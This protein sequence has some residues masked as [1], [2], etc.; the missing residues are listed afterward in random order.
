MKKSYR[1]VLVDEVSVTD[2]DM[3]EPFHS[4]DE[5]EPNDVETAE[6][7]WSETVSMP[8]DQAVKILQELRDKGADRVYLYTHSDHHGYYFTGVKLEEVAEG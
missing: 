8:I 3:E 1:E 7:V 4:P 2:L 5:E 6:E